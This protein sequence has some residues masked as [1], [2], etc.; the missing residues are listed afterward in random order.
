MESHPTT[1]E[2]LE[3]KL[4]IGCHAEYDKPR[5]ILVHTPGIEFSLGT[6]MPSGALFEGPANLYEAI[7]EH[8]N[9]QSQL[10]AAGS[11]VLTVSEV[12]LQGTVDAEHNTVE[13]P[14]LEQLQRLAFDPLQYTYEGINLDDRIRSEQKR[15][16][17]IAIKHPEE[18]VNIIFRQPQFKIKYSFEG[19]TAFETKY[20]IT[21][22]YNLMFVRDHMITT[23]KGVV[24]GTMNS[25]QRRSE[26]VVIRAVLEKLGLPLLYDLSDSGNQ[27]AKLEGGDFIPC[28][29]NKSGQSYALLGQG[30]RTTPAAID[31]LVV[32]NGHIIFGYDL[33]C[34]VKDSL[35]V[36][37]EMHLDTYFSLVAPHKAI[38]LEDRVVQ[39]N[40]SSQ[41][42]PQVDVYG[43]QQDGHYKLLERDVPFNSFL[44]Q[45]GFSDGDLLKLPE[46]MQRNY[47]LNPLTIDE[48]MIIGV[49]ISHK[50]GLAKRLASRGYDFA[51]LGEE[52]RNRLSDFGIINV[53]QSL[54]PFTHLNQAY[55]GPHCITQVFLRGE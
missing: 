22:M 17:V 4:N 53:E 55:G 14:A 8:K 33:V 40:G 54:V 15:Q 50:A 46:A 34:V 48:N 12:L 23:D 35:Q 25:S 10:R 2:K 11:Q 43:R 9:F 21:P 45:M 19:N 18:L 6:E 5:L 41:K 51:K 7:K 38:V 47:G 30:R 16:R 3:K 24:L 13:G 31:E 49:D 32:K 39:V 42:I 37:E 29:K 1:E 27:A 52:Y 26:I 36:Q 20:G 44:G 28:G